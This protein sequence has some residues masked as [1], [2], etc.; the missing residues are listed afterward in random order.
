VGTPIITSNVSSLPEVAGKAAIYINPNSIEDMVK[1]ISRIAKST[2]L[3]RQLVTKGL[4]QAR[5]FSWI[6][7]AKETLKV[8]NSLKI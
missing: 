7:T 6:K 5:Q 4:K 1:A 2:S 3:R 8:Y